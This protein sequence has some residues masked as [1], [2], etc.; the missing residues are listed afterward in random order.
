M[1]F[2]SAYINLPIVI[3]TTVD[4]AFIGEIK[5]VKTE[6]LG[7]VKGYAIANIFRDSI[8]DINIVDVESISDGLKRVESG[9]LFGYIDNLMVIENS[10]QKDF[11]GVLKVSSRLDEEAKLAVGTRNDEPLLKDIFEKLV[12]QSG[13]VVT[14]YAL[15]FKLLT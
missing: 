3:A 4:K 10:I 12:K 6:K 15:Q 1:D 2:T 9:E 8:K 11:T 14:R 5:S 13:M 7:M